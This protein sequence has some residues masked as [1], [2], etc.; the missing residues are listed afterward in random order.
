MPEEHYMSIPV[1]E[2]ERLHEREL[3]ILAAFYKADRL[4]VLNFVMMY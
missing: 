2:F 4:A 1:E 3:Q